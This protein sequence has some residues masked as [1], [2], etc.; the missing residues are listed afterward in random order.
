MNRVDYHGL[1]QAIAWEVADYVSAS[2][3]DEAQ[4]LIVHGEPAEGMCSLAWAIVNEDAHVPAHM[5]EA[6]LGHAGELV[7]EE[8]MQPKLADHALPVFEDGLT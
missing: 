8:Y 1:V 3:L 5:I 2:G 4:R 6:T 7:D